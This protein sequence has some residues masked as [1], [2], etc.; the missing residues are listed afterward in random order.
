MVGPVFIQGRFGQVTI[1]LG[2]GFGIQG[3]PAGLAFHAY[4][5]AVDKAFIDEIIDIRAV[6]WHERHKLLIH[7][8]LDNCLE[9]RHTASFYWFTAARFMQ[10][11]IQM[12]NWQPAWSLSA[13]IAVF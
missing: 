8:K 12:A 3:D 6:G 2:L 13:V 4:C 5:I 10:S 9:L 11:C 7:R 1:C